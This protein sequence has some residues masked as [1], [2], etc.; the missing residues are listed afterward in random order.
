MLVS[1]V[2]FEKLSIARSCSESLDSFNG[3]G[4]SVHVVLLA[5]A[6]RSK[7]ITASGTVVAENRVMQNLKLCI[8]HHLLS[9]SL[10]HEFAQSD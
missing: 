7:R 8:D 10:V 6:F 5:S 1:Y 4:S 9:L 3:L 2:N